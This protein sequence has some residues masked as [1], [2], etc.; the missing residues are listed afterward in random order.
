MSSES[1]RS[2]KKVLMD[3]RALSTSPQGSRL[4]KSMPVNG[5]TVGGR[6]REASDKTSSTLGA[7]LVAARYSSS[8]MSKKISS[9]WNNEE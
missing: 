6:R 8:N 5:V 3:L 2:L 9:L 4:V 1:W 7:G